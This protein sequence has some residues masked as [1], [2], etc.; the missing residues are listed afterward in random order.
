MSH[1][2]DLR[3][4]SGVRA[5]QADGQSARARQSCGR[6]AHHDEGREVAHRQAGRSAHGVA[7]DYTLGHAGRQVRV[8]PVA[9]WTIV[10]TL[11]I[12]A[13]WTIVTATYFA[14]HDD[15][16][17]RLIA[18]QA[19]LQSA[20]EDR[21]AEMRMQVDRLTSRQLLDQQLFE[22]K[23]D[24]LIRRQAT[25]ESRA[26]TLGTLADPATTGAIRPNGRARDAL[27][28]GGKPIGDRGALLP[29]RGSGLDV[30]ASAT[31]GRLAGR[32]L[33]AGVA[34]ALAWLQQ[35]LDR[36]EGRQGASLDAIEQSIERKARRIRTALADL[37][38]SVAKPDRDATGG[39]FVPVKVSP[40][41]A[42]EWQ[43]QRIHLARAHVDR[44]TRTLANVPVRKPMTGEL[45]AS[46]GFGVRTD[47][48]LGRPAMHTGID[49]R[50]QPGD[51]VRATAA[52]AV[53]QAGWNGG[54]GKLVEIDHGN[55]LSTRYGH[56]S[57]ISVAA[58]QTV[59]IG[60]ILGRLGSTGRS[61]GAHLHYETRVEGDA[62]DPQKFLRAGDKLGLGS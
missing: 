59:K 26:N 35:S 50:G 13:A 32:V 25:L 16:L 19:D 33:N 43:L 51:P 52:G 8:G 41:H 17:A 22:H 53:S 27:G 38:L 24:Q 1:S 6:H 30:G 37:G 7:A 54:Y 57:E 5:G 55:G 20:Y 21:I 61:T 2:C 29:E 10:G 44:L 14:F 9:F 23:L 60:Q 49:L 15:V 4:H 36:V 47:P 31:V 11:V 40:D 3:H 18:R 42:F 46:S 45:D 58:G 39:P 12:M 62:I 28:S 56:L 34:G 48:F